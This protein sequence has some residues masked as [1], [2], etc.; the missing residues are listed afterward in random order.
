MQ[1]NSIFQNCALPICVHTVYTRTYHV[2]TRTEVSFLLLVNLTEVSLTNKL[3]LV[4]DRCRQNAPLSKS[5]KARWCYLIVQRHKTNF[6]F[7]IHPSI[8]PKITVTDKRDSRSWNNHLTQLEHRQH[9]LWQPLNLSLLF[10]RSSLSAGAHQIQ[11]H[12]HTHRAI[13][14]LFGP[15]LSDACYQRAVK[16]KWD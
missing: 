3:K 13:N 9:C 5:I 7:H 14:A 11:T 1:N 12:T 8:H 16:L 10:I 4:S 6:F 2:Y 15:M